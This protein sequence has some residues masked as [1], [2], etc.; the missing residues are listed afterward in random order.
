MAQ[1]GEGSRHYGGLS[2]ASAGFGAQ[3]LQ[4]SQQGLCVRLQLGLHA[5][6]GAGDGYGVVLAT[7]QNAVGNRHDVI[8]TFAMGNLPAALEPF[9]DVGE[10]GR[11][12]GVGMA[13]DGL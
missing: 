3:A 6:Q 9:A 1:G 2:A 5:R 10:Q 11:R 12:V 4:G 7:Q 13:G 8:D